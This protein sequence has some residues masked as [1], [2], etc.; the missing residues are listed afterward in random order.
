MPTRS[1]RIASPHNAFI[2]ETSLGI[3]Y[4]PEAGPGPL[5][6]LVDRSVFD[7]REGCFVRN[8][9]PGLGVEI[10]EGGVR[11]EAEAGHRWRNPVWR[12]PDGSVAEW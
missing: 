8:D 5:D 9:S 3:H 12:L 7:R 4:H 6:Y 11:S 2:Q 10:D 1:S